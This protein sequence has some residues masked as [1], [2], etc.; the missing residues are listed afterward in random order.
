[1]KKN[2]MVKT[3]F[4]NILTAGVFAFTFGVI[5]TACSDE[6]NNEAAVNENDKVPAGA[7]TRLLEAYGLMY[8]DFVTEN[9]VEILNAD[10]YPRIDARQR[11]VNSRQ[12]E[13]QAQV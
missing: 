2:L 8:T 5:M 4:V 6:L 7:D 10:T 1:M 11:T 3:M 12:T 13:L 9:D